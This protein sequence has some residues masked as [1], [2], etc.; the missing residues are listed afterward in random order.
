MRSKTAPPVLHEEPLSALWRTR[1]NGG[2]GGAPAS[3]PKTYSTPASSTIE[4]S[5]T[6]HSAVASSA[7]SA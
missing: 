3:V 4:G 7:T 1:S 5:C 2:A 6:A